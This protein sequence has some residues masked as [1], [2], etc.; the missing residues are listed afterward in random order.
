MSVKVALAQLNSTVGDLQGNSFK[1]FN[2]SQRAAQQGADIVVTPEL[3]LVGYPPED[4]LCRKIF[5][6]KAN[7]ALTKLRK[8]LAVLRNVYVIVGHPACSNNKYFN[9]AS[10]LLNGNILATYN[11]IEL[12][13]YGIFDEKR[14]FSSSFQALT[15]DVK[16]IRFAV[17]ICEDVW[18]ARAPILAKQ[19]GAQVLLTLNSSP[20]HI[21]KQA[22]RYNAMR[23]NVTAHRMSLVFVNLV[24]GQ[25]ELVFDGNSFVLD[26]FGS[27]IIRLL[28]AAEDLQCVEFNDTQVVYS[29]V[30]S[31]SSSL[32]SCEDQIYKV[33]VLGVHDYIKKNNFTNVLLGLSGGVDSALTL[34]IAVDA[35]GADRVHAIMMPSIYT[36]NNS[37]INARN[38]AKNFCV[39]YDEI[40]INTCMSAFNAALYDEHLDIK[41]NVV[42]ENIQTRIRGTLLMAISNRDNAIVLTTTN[43]SEIA[44]G[45]CTLYGDIAGGFAVIKDV[46]KTLVYRLCVYRNSISLVIPDN[47]LKRAPSAELRFNQIDQDTLPPYY[48]LD[49]IIQ[50]YTEDNKSINE[51]EAAGYYKKDIQYIINR[52]KVNEYKRSQAPIGVRITQHAF[53]RD[54]RYPITSKF[55]E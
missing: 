3:A 37:L 42:F 34:A 39:R 6:E 18:F 15:F 48:I 46:T 1:I 26:M 2:F 14:Y 29:S 47:I 4:L 10:I 23:A 51:I 55:L 8:K 22:L 12:P 31:P 38:I 16:G 25:D 13:N 7:M 41:E 36:S 21:N 35:L 52:I 11:K 54:W 53:G 27:V 30:Q 9:S 24:G 19:A 44:V 50:M 20:Y 43:K 17:N 40:P 5:Y 28:H 32:P 49:K 33:L 45:Y